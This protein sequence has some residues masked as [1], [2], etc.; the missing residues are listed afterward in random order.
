MSIRSKLQED[1]VPNFKG[2]VTTLAIRLGLHSLVC[3]VEVLTENSQG[4]ILVDH[5][6]VHL[7]ENRGP[8]FIG[9]ER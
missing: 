5:L 6:L 9:Y 1:H 2:D 3:H 4:C 7:L 8:L